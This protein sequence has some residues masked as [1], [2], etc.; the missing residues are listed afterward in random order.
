MLFNLTYRAMGTWS[1]KEIL[2][3]L[4]LWGPQCGLFSASKMKKLNLQESNGISNK[5]W[6]LYISLKYERERE[7]ERK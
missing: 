3:Q 1:G 2:L 5:I 7:R 6:L 4:L